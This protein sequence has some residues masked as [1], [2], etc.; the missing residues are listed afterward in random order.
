MSLQASDLSR[1]WCDLGDHSGEVGKLYTC[2][3]SLGKLKRE[4]GLPP[5]GPLGLRR[6][7]ASP[8]GLCPKGALYRLSVQVIGSGSQSSGGVKGESS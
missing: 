5:G 4:P 6:Q 8:S 2:T 1:R 7:T 3:A